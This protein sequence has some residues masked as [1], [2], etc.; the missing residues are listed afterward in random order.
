M[1]KVLRSLLCALLAVM[2]ICPTM[3]HAE[4]ATTIKSG[5]WLYQ[6]NGTGTIAIMG[7]T[8]SNLNSITIPSMLDGYVVTEIGQSAFNNKTSLTSV[9]IPNSVTKIGNGAL[10]GCTGI[11]S[12]TIPNSVESLGYGSFASCTNLTTVRIEGN[13]SLTYGSLGSN[14]KTVYAY[15]DAS[16]VIAY[17][18]TYKSF[19]NLS[20]AGE[21]M[22][23]LTLPSAFIYKDSYGVWTVD[24]TNSTIMKYCGNVSYV[25]VPEK[26]TYN[27]GSPLT[28]RALGKHVF[29][30]SSTLNLVSINIP[31]V[32]SEAVYNCSKLTNIMF[33]NN[34]GILYSYA[35]K[36]CNNLKSVSFSGRTM[37]LNNAIVNNSSLCFY[38]SSNSTAAI[39]YA[40][41]N[42]IKYVIR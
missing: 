3:G 34:V 39:E 22:S 18:N 20:Y 7:N 15:K 9:T 19:L 40:K 21:K 23:K 4:A 42:S 29:E 31:Q 2:L 30:N 32:Y 28:I 24:G 25:V 16:K 13:P 10:C 27:N 11:K 38:C 12:I 1:K 35:I 37:L 26:V 5:D 14:S 8:K 17:C 36:D 6:S 33:G 41:K